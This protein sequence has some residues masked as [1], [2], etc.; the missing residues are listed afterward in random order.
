MRWSQRD[1]MNE[2]RY[3]FD[4]MIKIKKNKKLRHGGGNEITANKGGRK[5][6]RNRREARQ[7]WQDWIEGE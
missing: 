7:F 2:C 6:G 1:Q 4:G 3:V 5:E